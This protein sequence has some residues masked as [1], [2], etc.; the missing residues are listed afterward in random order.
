MKVKIISIIVMFYLLFTG[1]N[2]NSQATPVPE[3]QV[4]ATETAGKETRIPPTAEATEAPVI[5]SS[6]VPVKDGTPATGKGDIKSISKSYTD[7]GFNLFS[8]VEKENK[9]KNIFISPASVAFALSMT[10]NGA[11]GTTGDA[12]AEVL[13]FK[14][15]GLDEVNILNKKLMEGLNRSESKVELSIANSLWCKPDI[16]FKPDFIG[17]CKDFYDAEVS[18][19]FEADAINSWVKEKTKDKI[20]KIIDKIPDEGIL[21]LI[22]AIYFKGTWKIEFDKKKTEDKDFFL[23]NGSK[24]KCPLMSQRGD[25]SYYKGDK[26]QA[27]K[28]P[29]GDGSTG[30]YIFLPDEK[31]GLSEFQKNLTGKNWEKWMNGFQVM[32]GDVLLPRF[33][34]EYE[35]LLNDALIA[36]GM[37]IA[38]DQIKANFRNMCEFSQEENVCINRVIHKTFVEVNEKGTEAAAVTAVEMV[39]KT[40][41]VNPEPPKRF[42]MLVDHPFFFVIMDNKTGLILFMGSVVEP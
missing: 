15:M 22:N 10:G 5:E 1:C 8:E 38:F 41:S 27:V 25:F 14:G 12:M 3:T 13:Q 24:K 18:N 9:G 19:N 29:Y 2:Q 40:T 36:M 21:Y 4:P 6:Q 37:G 23:L 33:K 34:M 11:E 20:S 42:Y 35:L 16:K 39:L 17:R 31:T 32:K 28:L 30:M 7:F 26:F